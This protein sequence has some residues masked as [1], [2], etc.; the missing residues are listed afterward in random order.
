MLL[1]VK[2]LTTSRLCHMTCLLTPGIV[3]F[4]VS[5]SHDMSTNPA[6]VYSIVS[7]SRDWSINSCICL[8]YR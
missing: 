1:N 6:F 4:I 2:H 8:L 5:V 3:Y 7:V